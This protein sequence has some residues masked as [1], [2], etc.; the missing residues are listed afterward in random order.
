MLR[1][2]TDG[3]TTTE[4]PPVRVKWVERGGGACCPCFFLA[5]LAREKEENNEKW[6]ESFS[7]AIATRKKQE[8]RPPPP[9]PLR[10]TRTGGAS[11]VVTTSVSDLSTLRSRLPLAKISM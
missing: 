5:A 10:F 2:D 1:S 9:L 8:Q 11:V 3:A 6:H 7:R 4:T